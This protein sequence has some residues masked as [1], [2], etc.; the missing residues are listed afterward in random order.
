MIRWAVPAVAGEPHC[1]G[2]LVHAKN[3]VGGFLGLDY[4]SGGPLYR[5]GKQRVVPERW[6]Q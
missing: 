2:R 5:V 3:R 6:R 4:A 1:V